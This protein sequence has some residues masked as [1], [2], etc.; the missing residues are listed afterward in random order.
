LPAGLAYN[1]FYQYSACLSVLPVQVIGPFNTAGG[2]SIVVKK[3]QTDNAVQALSQNCWATVNGF[4]L[5]T[6]LKSKLESFTADQVLPRCPLPAVC[7][8]AK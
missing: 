8:R 1:I 2:A 4:G 7:S 5:T 3:T 6:M